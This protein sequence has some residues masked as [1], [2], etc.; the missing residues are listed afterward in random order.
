MADRKATMAQP[1]LARPGSPKKL[2]G[3]VNLFAPER[4]Q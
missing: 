2:R 4:N 3:G 1:V